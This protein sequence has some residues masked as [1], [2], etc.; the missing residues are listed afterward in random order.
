MSH[1]PNYA[2]IGILALIAVVIVSSC[3]FNYLDATSE[4]GV[5]VVES[6]FEC[7]IPCYHGSATNYNIVGT[8]GKVYVIASMCNKQMKSYPVWS[9]LKPGDRI[10]RV[11]IYEWVIEP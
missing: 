8:N 11:G 9:K 2:L 5:I 6:K 7:V 10:T 3:V 4:L 1:R